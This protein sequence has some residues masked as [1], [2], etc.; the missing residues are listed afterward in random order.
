MTC[1]VWWGYQRRSPMT[2]LR[3]F[4]R[5]T[6]VAS[7]ATPPAL[8]G[9]LRKSEVAPSGVPSQKNSVQQLF[10]VG[11][12]TRTLDELVAICGAN[13]VTKIADV[14]SFPGSRRNPQFGRGVLE[15]TLPAKGMAY[16]W[17]PALGG[18]RHRARAAPPS[19]WRV[20]GFAAYADHMRGPDFHAGI[21]QLL[22]ECVQRS[23]AVMCAEASPYR[24]HRRLISDWAELHGI[25][26]VHLLDERR[27]ERHHV[28]PFAHRAGDDVVYG[29][30]GGQ[31]PLT[32]DAD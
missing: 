23:T 8:E 24:C 27:R 3:R 2:F 6:M 16:L 21:D 1:N 7:T 14:R 4:A 30:N 10:T 22:A 19:P 15:S 9:L 25:E 18:R 5:M 13:G 20:A 26:V 32:V 28:T 11:H 29:T 12:S 17:I 31:L